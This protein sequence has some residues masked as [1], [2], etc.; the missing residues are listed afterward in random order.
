MNEGQLLIICWGVEE[1][2]GGN[3]EWQ[4][5]LILFTLGSTEQNLVTEWKVTAL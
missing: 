2:D 1:G 4:T 5:F 3:T